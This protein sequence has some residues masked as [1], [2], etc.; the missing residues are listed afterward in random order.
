MTRCT[1]TSLV[2]ARVAR[3]GVAR[4]TVVGG[5]THQH[6]PTIV[7]TPGQGISRRFE[8]STIVLNLAQKQQVLALARSLRRIDQNLSRNRLPYLKIRLGL[9]PL[10]AAPFKTQDL[11]G[12]FG[13]CITLHI[14]EQFC[15]PLE[16]RG[17]GVHFSG[18]GL[19]RTMGRRSGL[20]GLQVLG[21]AR[22]RSMNANMHD[23]RCC[24]K[25]RRR[26]AN[27]VRPYRLSI[28]QLCTQSGPLRRY[29]ERMPLTPAVHQVQ[30]FFRAELYPSL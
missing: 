20:S 25:N 4:Q 9:P 12:S 6:R 19:T 5:G 16:L 15:W 24:I 14:P 8:D 23:G 7:E 10:F 26:F 27:F 30:K 3:V 17:S 21:Q 29:P 11:L 2:L 1:F 18:V 13:N 28:V 22:L